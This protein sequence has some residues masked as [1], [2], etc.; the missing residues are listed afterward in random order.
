MLSGGTD[1]STVAG[2]LALIRGEPVDT[3]SIGFAADGYDEM[4]FA[5][6]ASRHLTG[7]KTSITL[8]WLM[9]PWDAI[10]LIAVD[11]L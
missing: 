2:Y 3:Y 10:L 11:N 7:T 4:S 1:S 8:P 6:I 5:R 9:S